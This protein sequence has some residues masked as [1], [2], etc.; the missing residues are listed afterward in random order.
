VQLVIADTDPVNYLIV[1]GC[2]DLLPRIFE[3]IVL[4]DA[5]HTELSSSLAPPA[6]QRWIAD[7]AAWLEIAQTPGVH[8][9]NWNSQRRGRGDRSGGCNALRLA[10]DR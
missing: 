8:S 3:R 9:F 5:V 10:V 4:P 7:P 6:V 2:I 1:I